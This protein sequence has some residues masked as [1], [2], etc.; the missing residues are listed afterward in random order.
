MTKWKMVDRIE[1]L[2]VIIFLQKFS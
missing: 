2:M 1:N